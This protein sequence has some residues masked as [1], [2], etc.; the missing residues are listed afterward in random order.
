MY[1]FFSCFIWRI[2]VA[3]CIC[4]PG[5]FCQTSFDLDKRAGHYFLTTTVN[6]LPDTDIFVETGFSGLTLNEDNFD[7][8][9]ASSSL[10]KVVFDEDAKMRFDNSTND[11]VG[12]YFGKV[13]VGGLTYEGQIW[14]IKSYDKIALP[15]HKLKNASDTATSLVRLDFKNKTL[16]FVRR[17]DVE[18]E[19]MKCY[20]I[21]RSVPYPTFE[22]KLELSDTYGNS[23]ETTG[24]WIF[25]LGCGTPVFFFRKSIAPFVNANKFKVLPSRDKSGNAGGQGIYAQYC[26]IGDQKATAISIGITNRT[27]F[28]YAL[29]CVGPSFFGK[30]AVILDFTHNLIYYK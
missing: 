26:R 5:A 14:V 25:D 6:G 28:D 23:G 1:K 19:K 2:A 3:F 7:K 10:E 27:S 9:F 18:L 30:G 17:D 11:V 15:I 29:G 8:L 24:N 4:A 22:A 21:V 16:D 20:R 13:P 12:S